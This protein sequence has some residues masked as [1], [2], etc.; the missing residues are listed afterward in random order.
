MKVLLLHGLES[1]PGGSKAEAIKFAGHKLINPAL[2]ADN[3]NDSLII[4][5]KAIDEHNPDVVVGSSRGG[6]LVV[7]VDTKNARRVLIAPAW[8]KYGSQTANNI[9]G[10]TVILHALFDDV[11]PFEDS[12][13]LSEM[14]GAKLV[15][16]GNDHRMNTQDVLDKLVRLI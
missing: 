13:M 6:A 15:V 4:T 3:W 16:I 5:Q 9:P 7:N 1:C 12:R 10:S 8:K 14:T 2:P 11:I